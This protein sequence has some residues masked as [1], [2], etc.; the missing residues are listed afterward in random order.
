MSIAQT[1]QPN[2][3]PGTDEVDIG[4]LFGIL[5]DNRWMIIITT[6]IFAVVGIGYA[7]LATPI[8]KADALIQIEAKSSGMPALG[9]DMAEMFGGGESSATTETEI[10]KS[11]MVLGET[12]DKL[13]LTTVVS[14]EYLP[15]VG[16]GLA[17]LMGEQH[18]INVSRFTVA[19]GREL[20]GYQ[21]VV[22]NAEQGQYQLNDSDSRKVLTGKVGEL[23]QV[24]GYQLFVTDLQAVKGAEFALSKISR[25][26]A[27]QNLQ[28]NLAVAEQG[29]QTGILQLSMTGENR[30]D[31][32]AIVDDI[33]KNYFLQ[34]VER[35]SAEAENSL[36]FLKQ[37]LPEIKTQLTAAEDK[38][39]TY[40][41]QNESV[42]LSLEA[43][44][45]LESMVGL[46]SQ[47]NQ[48]TFKETDISQ[49]FTKEHPAYISLMDKR[50]TLMKEQS[51]LNKR[52][53]TLPKT[54][55]AILRL[56]RDVEVNQQIYV[57]LLNKVQELNIVKAST[58]GNVRI[59][60]A[61]QV[62][63]NAVKPKKALIVVLATLLGGMLSVAIAFLRAALHRGVES[64]DEIEALGLPVYASIP[65]SD[66]QTDLEKKFKSKQQL[67]INQ[68]L[69]AVA[70]PADLSI[71][72]LRSL[73]T[74][75]HFAMMEARNNIVMISGPSPGIGKSFVS[76]NMA[77]VMAKGGQRVLVIDAD[78]RKGRMERQ[79]CVDSKPGLADYLSGQ[80]SIEQVIKSPGVENLDFIARGAVPPN[81]SELLMHPRLK[82]LLDWASENYDLVLVDTPPILAV[83]D[84]AIVGAHAGT[85][86]IVARFGLNPVKEIEVTKNRFEQNGI[87]V[88]GCILNA[89][90]RKASSTYGGNYGYY[91][92]SYASDNK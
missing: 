90:V 9:G 72:A 87:E 30:A 8:Y 35:N 89:V 71:E 78:M 68:A 67:Q 45:A 18:F 22:T 26:D 77:A 31:I 2:T 65:L 25:L 52:I 15:V 16:K 34:N 36:V 69:L 85:T 4:K 39:N 80:Q 10:I 50:K 17:R 59:L 32:K 70:N 5:I 49:R 41:Q 38:L 43:K 84:P 86:M 48:L 51:R 44:S 63:T 20:G 91:N 64:P 83:T 66:W 73:R 46:E 12:V 58:V 56:T 29:K 74:S 33:S 23:A 7:L 14:P 3:S 42:D 13:N 54:Q 6:F 76:A 37:H 79:M 57:Q 62:Y 92:Y 75:L 28:R 19:D 60:D 82:T 53:E 81:P 47:L 88:K 27:I 21:I 40:R 61:A 11:R 55:R 24:N 1:P